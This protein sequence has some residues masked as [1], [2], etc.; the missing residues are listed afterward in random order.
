[1]KTSCYEYGWS[2]SRCK[3][4]ERFRLEFQ[5][6]LARY[7]AGHRSIAVGFGIVWEKTLEQVP[8]DDD[9]QATA[10]RELV[11]WARTAELFTP[12]QSR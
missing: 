8:L 1:M 7:W 12:L 6:G 3:S 2:E 10:Y 5:R 11:H 4:Q 9:L